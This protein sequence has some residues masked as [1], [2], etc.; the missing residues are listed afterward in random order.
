[1][2]EEAHPQLALRLVLAWFVDS[3]MLTGVS[4][5]EPPSSSQETR[6][7]KDRA[8]RNLE[9]ARAEAVR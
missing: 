7:T 3:Q 9:R 4:G 6:A 5:A 2:G 1:M 8:F